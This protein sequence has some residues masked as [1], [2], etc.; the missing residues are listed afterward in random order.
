MHIVLVYGTYSNSTYSASM[1]VQD[2]LEKKGHSVTVVEAL[3]VT[4]ELLEQAEALIFASPSWDHSGHQGMPHEDYVPLMQLVG[5]TTFP[6]KQCAVMGLGDNSYTYFCGAVA[7]LEAFIQK[8]QGQLV[9]DSLKIDQ[10]YMDEPAN[11]IKI[12]AWGDEL[13]EK[14]AS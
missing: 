13:A 6:G 5:D 3:A 11:T 9:I 14:L 10:Y 7:H 2:T 4:L 1:T 8:F 12:Q